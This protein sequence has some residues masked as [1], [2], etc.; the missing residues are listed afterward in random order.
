MFGR[1]EDFNILLATDGYKLTHWKQYPPGTEIVYSY[2]ES[3]GGKFPSTVFFGLQYFLR[4]YMEGQVVTQEKIDEASAK[5]G[6][7]FGT[8]YFNREGWEYIL[9]EY[10]G[11]LPVSIRA[12]PEGT[13]VPTSNVLM[14]IENTDPK[15][16]W[17]TNYLETMLVEVWYPT[18]VAT[19]SN[20]IRR[21]LLAYLRRTGSD[22][23][24]DFMFHDF[25]YRGVSSQESAGLGGAAHLLN[26]NGSDT[27][28]GIELLRD[29]YDPKPDTTIGVTIPASEHSTI[30]SWGEDREIDAFRNMLTSYP[31]GPVACVSD[32]YNIFRACEDYWGRELRMLVNGRDGLLVV[33]P[34][35]GDPALVDVKCL[36]LLG[37]A[38]GYTEN[39]RGFKVINP[40]VRIIQGDGVDYESVSEVLNAIILDGWAAENMAFGCGGALLQRLDRD[41]QKFAF[42]C[43]AIRID[44]AWRDVYKDPIT[45]PGKKSKRGRLR[46]VEARGG[47]LSTMNANGG[48]ENDLL[49]EVFF[50]GAL[51]HPHTLE[52][53][54]AR[55]RAASE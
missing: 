9:R 55:A 19:L 23:G 31:T 43:S 12:V 35:S 25:G 37:E 40:K 48:E 17:L 49:V 52:N 24:I 39:G 26:F 41:T 38:F 45:D 16:F 42:K 33:R 46:L 32:S 36:K 7:Y 47:A 20:Y 29:Y 15:C 13:D 21:K 2:L 18:T 27:I 51:T 11:R 3:R 6:D 53:V 28:A 1:N 14:T 10:G 8:D 30:T 5:I 34:D 50:N 22:A 54:R 44:G 4:R